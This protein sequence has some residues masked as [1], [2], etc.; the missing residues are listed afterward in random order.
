MIDRGIIQKILVAGVAAP[1]GDNTQPWSFSVDGDAIIINMHPQ[2][3]HPIL[4]VESR[5]TLLATGALLENIAIAARHEGLDASIRVFER[6][7]ETARIV[8]SYGTD[9]GHALHHTIHARHT[10]RG[11][12]AKHLSD[13]HADVLS[14]HN[15]EHC[16]L[17]VVSDTKQISQIAEAASMMEETALRTRK[18]HN[19]FFKSILWKS[20]E[21]EAGTTGLY[22]KT[23]ELPPP[24]QALFRLIR[25]WPIM[26]TLNAL[27]FPKLA[28][29]SNASVYAAS[30][31]ILAILLDRTEPRDFISAG[32]LMQRVWLTA[33]H[34]GLAAQPLAGLLYLAEYVARSNDSDIDE[35]LKKRILTAKEEIARIIVSGGDTIAMMLRIGVPE[36]TASARTRRRPPRIV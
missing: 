6:E 32:R 31:A 1:S 15:E 20:H 8:L 17:V 19:L 5:G 27:G 3:D 14:S 21:N 28:A 18:L 25:H 10:N 33:E 35:S 34:H 12:Y 29:K 4:N 36:R 2:M 30:G 16:R 11:I 23:T 13:E 26:R 22:I 7:G 24:I 9:K